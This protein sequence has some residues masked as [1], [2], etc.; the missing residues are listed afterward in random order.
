[1]RAY[2]HPDRG[3]FT[4]THIHIRTCGQLYTEKYETQ[5]AYMHTCTHT[6]THTYI[7]IQGTCIQAGTH[8]R[9]HIHTHIHIHTYGHTE[10]GAHTVI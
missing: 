4:H 1:M 2:I 7:L 8:M 9:T 6:Y 5:N 10:R 3:T